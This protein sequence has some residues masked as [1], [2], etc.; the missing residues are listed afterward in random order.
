MK[1]KR[2]IQP[3]WRGMPVDKFHQIRMEINEEVE[4]IEALRKVC[5][6]VMDRLNKA[7][8][9]KLEFTTDSV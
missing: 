6:P 7:I 3:I 9:D 8:T 1:S 2:W 5:Q 4:G